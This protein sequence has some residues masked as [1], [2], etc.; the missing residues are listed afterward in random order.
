MILI[1]Q[2]L[3]LTQTKMYIKFAP[4]LNQKSDNWTLNMVLCSNA[5]VAH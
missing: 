3:S 2:Y 4:Y 5:D 1:K